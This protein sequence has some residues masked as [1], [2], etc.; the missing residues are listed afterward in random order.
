VA[1]LRELADHW[2]NLEHPSH[3]VAMAAP[4]PPA[5]DNPYVLRR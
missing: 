2:T 3:M 5:A 1:Y 4:E